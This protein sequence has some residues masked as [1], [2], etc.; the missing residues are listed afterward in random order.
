MEAAKR[1]RENRASPRS[2]SL[3]IYRY[4]CSAWFGLLCKQ[5][6]KQTLCP[7]QTFLGEDH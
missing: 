4:I 7:F 6:F 5:F 2:T 1:N 3:D